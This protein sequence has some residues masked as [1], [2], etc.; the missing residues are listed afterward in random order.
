M[1]GIGVMK[2]DCP[3]WGQSS[4]WDPVAALMLH[5]DVSLNSGVTRLGYIGARALATRGRAPATRGRAAPSVQVPNQIIGADS[6]TQ[7]GR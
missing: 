5:R 6:I 2:G 1:R 3:V 7:I 4:D